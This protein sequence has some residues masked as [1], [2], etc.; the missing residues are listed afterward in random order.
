MEADARATPTSIKMA[1][2]ML[3]AEPAINFTCE[4]SSSVEDVVER[5]LRRVD[6]AQAGAADFILKVA[7]F[8]FLVFFRQ[9]VVFLQFYRIPCS[10]KLS[11]SKPF[12]HS[13][14]EV[15]ALVLKSKLSR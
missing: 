9:R 6:A 14:F 12:L 8:C 4:V 5:V 10:T 3:G 15:I 1:V 11:K 2:L 13:C 7:P